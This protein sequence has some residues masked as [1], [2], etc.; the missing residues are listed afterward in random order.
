MPIAIAKTYSTPPTTIT[1]QSV[2]VELTQFSKD[3]KTITVTGVEPTGSITA[4]DIVHI[5]GTKAV[6]FR[7]NGTV[8]MFF[9]DDYGN[10]GQEV[11]TISNIVSTP[12]QIKA[13]ATLAEDKLS[14]NVTFDQIR[15]NDGVPLDILRKLTDLTVSYRG[16]EHALL[17]E[18]KDETGDVLSYKEAVINVKTNGEHVF[19]VRDQT[20]ITQKILVT[21]EGIE[22]GGTKG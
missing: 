22:V 20:G 5:P 4:N 14:V 21:V 19:Q 1:A 13:T 16:Y 18:V 8:S 17:T 3:I 2:N 7:K 15:D 9:V 10:E 6:R 12:P 11:I